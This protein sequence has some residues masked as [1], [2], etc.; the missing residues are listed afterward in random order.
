MVSLHFF[1]ALALVLAASAVFVFCDVAF[2]FARRF[3]CAPYRA[4]MRALNSSS[5][6]RATSR[7][8]ARRYEKAR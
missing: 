5:F 7:S 2:F 6:F 8:S 3:A 4:C 1:F